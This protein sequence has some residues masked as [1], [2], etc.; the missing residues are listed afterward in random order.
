MVVATGIPP[1]ITASMVIKA[2]GRMMGARTVG[3]A[4]DQEAGEGLVVGGPEGLEQ[5]TSAKMEEKICEGRIQSV[6][7]FRIF[8]LSC[9][10][11]DKE[12]LCA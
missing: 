4:E 5:S 9:S 1:T 11:L 10:C 8:F 6:D 2:T 7:I 3:T 12:K